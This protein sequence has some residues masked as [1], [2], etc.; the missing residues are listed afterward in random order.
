MGLPRS[1]ASGIAVTAL[2]RLFSSGTAAGLDDATLLA[3]FTTDR[4]EAAFEALVRRHGP[5]VLGVL[6]RLLRDPNDVDDA[7]QATFV[8]LV[9]KAA[10]LR[11]GDL[12]ANWLYGVAYRVALRARGLAALRERKLREGADRGVLGSSTGVSQERS[13]ELEESQLSLHA[14]LARLPARYRAALV[15]CYLEGLTNDQAAERLGCPPGTLKGRLARGKAILSRRLTRRGIALTAAAIGSQLELPASQAAVPQTLESAAMAAAKA[16]LGFHAASTAILSYSVTTLAQGV[17]TAM[18]WTRVKLL[19]APASIVICAAGML[20]ASAAGEFFSAAPLQGNPPQGRN[21]GAPQAG[22]GPRSPAANPVTANAPPAANQQ[23]GQGPSPGS[24]GVAASVPMTGGSNNAGGSNPNAAQDD[25]E[26]WPIRVARN[27]ALLRKLDRSPRSQA[28]WK[29]LDTPI[30]L[31]FAAE[32]P[33]EDVLKRIKQAA[34]DSKA[35]PLAIYID[36]IGLSEAEKSLSSTVTI[37]LEDIPLKDSLRLLLRE[38]G[39]A[40]CVHNGILF[41]SSVESVIDE[42]KLALLELESDK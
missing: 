33:L 36:P 11:R 26:Y 23:G 31:S 3:R 8:I 1:Q 34:R 21:A 17:L 13:S 12:M 4:D 24:M 32:T 39:L 29:F 16:T 10:S 22:S 5:M 2:G 42:Q 27:D 41:I 9:R 6:R 18:Y 37:E 7:F 30:T 40:F 20:A 28:V 15:L 38:I 19:I 35:A 25:S 14:E